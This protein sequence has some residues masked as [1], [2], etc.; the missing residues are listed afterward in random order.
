MHGTV[1]L[2][3]GGGQG[4]EHSTKSPP[5]QGASE[6][7]ALTIL[8]PQGFCLLSWKNPTPC[9][10]LS[11]FSS[12]RFNSAWSLQSTSTF[13]NLCTGD[14]SSLISTMVW[15]HPPMATMCNLFKQSW[16]H[17]CK[18]KERRTTQS[19]HLT[20]AFL[21]KM[22]LLYH[23]KL[24]VYFLSVFLHKMCFQPE[25]QL[26]FLSA[27]PIPVE[28]LLLS[29]PDPPLWERANILPPAP[30]PSVQREGVMPKLSST[31]SVLV[32][33]KL[34]LPEKQKW[35]HYRKSSMSLQKMQFYCTAN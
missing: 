26:Q 9:L 30:T 32:L 11:L 25:F 24:R 1:L 29:S 21:C 17:S 19:Q 7:P 15:L 5:L 16:H 2:S 33:R 4:C 14:Y 23:H 13:F 22:L 34:Q 20:A 18:S 12:C 35:K 10:G 31:H 28:M 8:I 3:S 27:S 6:S